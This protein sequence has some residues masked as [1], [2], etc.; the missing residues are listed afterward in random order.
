M[1]KT[2]FTLSE[3]ILVL[4]I[5]GIIGLLYSA[6]M[7]LYNPTQKGFDIQASK[8][9]ESIDQVF[10]FIFAKH[11]TS[12]NLTDLHDKNGNFS[13]T[14]ENVLPRFVALFK[15]YVNTLDLQDGNLDKVKDYYASDIINYDRTST[16]LK[17]KDTYSNFITSTNGTI[18]GFRLYKSC[19]ADELNANPP[20]SQKRKK[21]SNVCGSIFYDVNNYKGPNKLGS[22]QYIVPFD[23]Q[24]AEIKK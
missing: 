3:A 23:E 12:F 21:V 22:D 5:M 14:D 19:S 13:I 17:L 6:G 9:L 2:A 7:K 15:E 10:N 24:G 20:L 8:A 16:G 11:S 4:A 18:F 1:K